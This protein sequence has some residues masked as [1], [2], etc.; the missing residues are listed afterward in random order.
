MLLHYLFTACALFS[1]CSLHCLFASC[2]LR[3]HE[4]LPTSSLLLP[5]FFTT[6]S[7]RLHHLRNP[8]FF[9]ST[10]LFFATIRWRWTGFAAPT[11]EDYQHKHSLPD[12]AA[13]WGDVHILDAGLVVRKCTPDFHVLNTV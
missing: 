3:A 12:E 2:S 8:W 11:P 9:F 13:G 4:L 7:L 6:S 10:D 5:Y 1:S